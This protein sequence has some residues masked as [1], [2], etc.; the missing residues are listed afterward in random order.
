MKLFDHLQTAATELSPPP[1]SLSPLG[2]SD[3]LIGGLTKAEAVAGECV[4]GLVGFM[5]L[6]SLSAILLALHIILL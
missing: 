1:E 5:S 3:V 2:S 4:M 6:S